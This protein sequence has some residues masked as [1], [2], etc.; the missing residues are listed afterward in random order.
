[1]NHE[2]MVKEGNRLNA[3]LEI[4]TRIVQDPSCLPEQFRVVKATGEKHKQRLSILADA[5]HGECN[6][7]HIKHDHSTGGRGPCLNIEADGTKC[8]CTQWAVEL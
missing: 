1:M 2:E 3:V 7:G 5:I 8:E 6:C 4:Q